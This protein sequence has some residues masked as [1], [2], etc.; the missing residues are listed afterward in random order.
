V[1]VAMS[2]CSTFFE[3]LVVD[4]VSV[5]DIAANPFGDVGSANPNVHDQPSDHETQL[6]KRR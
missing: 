4:E 6:V 3:V 5:V 1:P 2:Q